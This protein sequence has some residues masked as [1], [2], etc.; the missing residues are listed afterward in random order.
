MK[1]INISAYAASEIR[2][3][4]DNTVIISINEE[5]DELYKLKVGGSSVFRTRFTDCYLPFEHKQK[6]YRPI[7]PKIANELLDFI[8]PNI[9]KNFI[10][11]CAAGVSRSAAVALFLNQIFGYELK[12][13]FW[14]LSEPNSYIF[15][16]LVVEY[17]KR[18]SL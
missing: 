16:C 4:P 3:I 11:H 15:G 18:K 9:G 5:H 8:I 2:E 17:L 6:K 10:I 1:A 13:N 7:D 14:H 12:E